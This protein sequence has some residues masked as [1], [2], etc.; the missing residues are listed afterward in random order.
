MRAVGLNFGMVTVL[1]LCKEGQSTFH[2]FCCSGT[3]EEKPKSYC[4]LKLLILVRKILVCGASG[5][6]GNS[7]VIDWCWLVFC[8]FVAWH[9]FPGG[10]MNTEECGSKCSQD[11]PTVS[12]KPFGLDLSVPLTWRMGANPMQWV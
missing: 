2:V 9:R 5:I 6:L 7:L 1:T 8:L 12:S 11:Y 3:L 4:R 10:E